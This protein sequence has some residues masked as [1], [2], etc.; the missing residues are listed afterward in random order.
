MKIYFDISLHNNG[1]S[2]GELLTLIVVS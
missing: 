1:K 2:N